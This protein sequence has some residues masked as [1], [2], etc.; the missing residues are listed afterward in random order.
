M[1]DTT[2][3]S[4]KE[5]L[6][7][8]QPLEGDQEV[9]EGKGLK[10]LTP[11]KLITSLSVLLAQV[12]ARN[13]PIRLKNESRQIVYLLYQHNKITKTVCNNLMKSL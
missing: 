4:E 13:N 5:K 1:A 12:K 6:D 7:D 8:L 11:N 10:V 2:V 9:S 3:R